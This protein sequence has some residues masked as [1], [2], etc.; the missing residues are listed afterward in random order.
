MT[1]DNVKFEWTSHQQVA[2]DALKEAISAS[3]VLA[4]ADMSLPFVVHTDASG[5]AIGAVLQQDQGKGLQ[6]IAYL[7]KKMVDAETRYPVHEQELLAIIYALK[8]WRHYL[9]GKKFTVMTDHR[10]LESFKTQPNLSGR[11]TRWKDAIANFD[12]DIKYIAGP[13][14][15][16]ADGLSRRCDHSS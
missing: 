14:N 8:K 15:V 13:T 10:S 16:V 11:Q 1:K 12:F 3:P 7:S 6:P 5:F 9:S 4:I 2:F